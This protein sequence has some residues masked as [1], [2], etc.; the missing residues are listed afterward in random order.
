MLLKFSYYF[1][2][3]LCWTFLQRQEQIV[4]DTHALRIQWENPLDVNILSTERELWTT[5]HGDYCELWMC[6]MI[7]CILRH[8]YIQHTS[9][10]VYVMW[11]QWPSTEHVLSSLQSLTIYGNWGTCTH[12][13]IILCY[14]RKCVAN[15][16]SWSIGVILTKNKLFYKPCQ[17]IRNALNK[18]KVLPSH[19]SLSHTYL[20]VYRSTNWLI[21]Y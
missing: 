15:T 9:I 16:W 13:V 6:S 2:Q 7:L 3:R 12:T 11:H 14:I 18:T 1:P 20:N 10:R 21:Q 4:T 8:K 19:K 17:S 5:L